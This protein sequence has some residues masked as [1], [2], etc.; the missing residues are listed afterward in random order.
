VDEMQTS[1][2]QVIEHAG[3][4]VLTTQQLAESYGT[5]SRRITENFNRN[6]E[7][8]QE[9]EHYFVL[10]GASLMG[11]A[12]R[13][14]NCVSVTRISKMYLWTEKGC[15]LHAKSL[16]TAKAWEVYGV[17]MDTYFRAKEASSMT[18]L[19]ILAKVVNGMVL[20]ERRLAEQQKQLTVLQ[21][22]VN[23]LDAVNATGDRRQLLNKMVQRLAHDRGITFAQ[24]WKHFDE[25]FN[26]AYR[27]N[28][29]ARRNNY[30]EAH[31]MRE[32]ARPDYLERVGLLE[33]AI[34]V[35]DKLLNGTGR[36]LA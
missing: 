18:E 28:L 33:D 34:R 26:F 8:Y 4:R 36:Q 20:Q 30:A 6:S 29:T 32:I 17:L 19:E 27:A 23:N 1:D 31:N 14:A 13:Y 9:G 10:E 11:F 24:A 7:R 22:R 15:L 5:D 16:N 35:M 3:Q 21:H 2:L 12:N 25:A